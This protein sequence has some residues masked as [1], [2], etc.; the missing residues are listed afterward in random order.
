MI[1][2]P[3]RHL[4]GC[5]TAETIWKIVRESADLTIAN[6]LYDIK[7]RI[8]L[9][10]DDADFDYFCSRFSILDKIRWSDFAICKMAEQ[11]LFDLKTEGIEHCTLTVSLN[12]FIRS[13]NAV[14][15][16]Y[17][18]FGIL[19]EMAKEIGIDVSYLLSVSYNWPIE[20]QLQMLDLIKSIKGFVAG[21]DFVGDES[22]ARW[23][24]Y[25]DIIKLWRREDKAVRVH[26]AERPGTSNNLDLALKHLDITRI[27]HGIYSTEKQQEEAIRRGIVFDMSLHSNIYTHAIKLSDHP[28]KRMQEAGCKITLG[29]DD[30]VQFNCSI[31]NE[32]ALAES[33]GVDKENIRRTTMESMI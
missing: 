8:Y 10:D 2:E 22:L 12:K 31:H 32:Y 25:T 19:D 21:V 14:C 15:T 9:L 13:D 3:H 33:I 23:P 29:A 20:L 27:A 30:P 16:G 1:I 28:I 26:I 24:E 5:I 17:R 18:V 7:R 4:A 11:V 6:S